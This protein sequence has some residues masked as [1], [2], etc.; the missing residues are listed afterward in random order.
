MTQIV[1]SKSPVQSWS[2]GPKVAKRAGLLSMERDVISS[3]G[4]G[5]KPEVTRLRGF[6]LRV[7][8]N[9]LSSH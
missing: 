9:F 8:D 1:L 4:Y 2:R 5:G 3:H 6:T 7:S